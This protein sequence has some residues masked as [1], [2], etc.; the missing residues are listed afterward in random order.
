MSIIETL[1]SP[2]SLE[3][4][5]KTYFDKEPFAA[6]FKAASMENLVSWYLLSEILQSGHNNC[7]LP[8]HGRLPAEPAL[9]SGTLT[10]QQALKG[11]QE[12]RTVLVRHAEQAHPV[13]QNIARDF[14]NCF[15]APIDIQLYCTPA[16]QEGFDWHYDVEQVFV[17]QTAG[18]KEFRLRKNTVS[19]RPLSMKTSQKDDFFKEPPGPEIRC[20][21]KAGDWLYIPAGYWHKAQALTNS[22]HMSV[23][24]L[25]GGAEINDEAR[26]SYAG[27]ARV[28]TCPVVEKRNLFDA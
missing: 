20:W 27:E 12:G 24:V 9:S 25:T 5:N 8:H 19:A 15:K 26:T 13:M 18:E 10:Y 11:F 3:E 4:F 16:G 6:P 14:H 1:L 23:G 21:L 22:C 2:L 28:K 7:W 17:I